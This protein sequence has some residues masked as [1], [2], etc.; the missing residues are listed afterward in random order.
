MQENSRIRM[1]VEAL[2]KYRQRQTDALQQTYARRVEVIRDNYH[3]QADMLR[4]SYAAQLERFR[5][6]RAAQIG[7]VSQH[8]EAMRENYNTQA[9]CSCLA[10]FYL[11]LIYDSSR[12]EELATMVA[13]RWSAC[14]IAISNRL[15][16]F[17]HSRYNR[18]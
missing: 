16:A 3:S 8:F 4:R 14:L 7:S 13:D 15:I 6:Y 18:D 2:E 5:D 10:R 1:M 11:K 9:S 17:E 12:L